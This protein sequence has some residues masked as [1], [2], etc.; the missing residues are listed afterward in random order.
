MSKCGDR[1]SI[2]QQAHWEKS[3]LPED[4]DHRQIILTIVFSKAQQVAVSQLLEPLECLLMA[5]Q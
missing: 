4:F 3:R 2:K 5:V 1:I